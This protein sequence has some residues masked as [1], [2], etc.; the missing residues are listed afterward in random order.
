MKKSW[1]KWEVLGLLWVAFFL[2][3]ADRQIYNTLLGEISQSLQISAEQAGLIATLFNLVFAIS[4]P[5]FGFLADNISKKKILVFAILLWSIATTVSGCAT[6]FITFIIFR[7]MATG[8]G[9]GAFGPANYSTIADYHAKDTRATA[10]SIHQTSYYLGVII[11]GL[12]ASW[13]SDMYGWRFVF[14]LFGSLGVVWGFI[15]IVRLKDKEPI[16]TTSENI[17]AKPSFLES[18]KLF[19]SIPTA[20]CLTLAYA[21]LIFVLQGY[22]TW[23][24]FYLQEK[25]NLGKIDAGFSAMFY[26]HIAALVGIL[27]AGKISDFFAKKKPQYRILL[28]SLG[29]ITAVPFIIL[30][31]QS[32]TLTFVYIGFVGF[33]FWRAFFDANTYAVLYDVI[34]QKYHATATGVQT[35]VGFGIGAFS[36]WIL[37]MLKPQLG[38]SMG[39]TMLSIP[40]IIFAVVLFIAY[41]FFYA[42]DCKKAS[43]FM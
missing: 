24:T 33:G 28:Q 34:P 30:M 9:E 43:E 26:T 10:M 8:L 27:V 6:G 39:I 12:I 22:L 32:T 20:I 7:S 17:K 25:F 2:N 40:W 11:T 5:L 36:P 18:L 29:L 14:V 15:M 23:S 31:G 1:Y 35:F 16:K 19:F 13:L 21:S 3:Q 37:G 38:L 42:R 4:V 41:K